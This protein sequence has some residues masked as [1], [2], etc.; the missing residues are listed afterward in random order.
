MQKLCSNC[1]GAAQFSVLGV[2]STVG[3]S[4]RLQQSSAAVLFC[5]DCLRELCV[6]LGSDALSDAVNNAYTTLHE[7]LRDRSRAQTVG[8]D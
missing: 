2:V 6:R 4:G 1:S 8:L 3:I 5:N 7:R